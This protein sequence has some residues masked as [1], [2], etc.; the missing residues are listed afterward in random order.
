MLP[1]SV[2]ATVATVVLLLLATFA[3][4]KYSDQAAQVAAADCKVCGAGM[5]NDQSGQDSISDCKNCAVWRT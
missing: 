2:A 1:H 4:G 3:V 5:Y